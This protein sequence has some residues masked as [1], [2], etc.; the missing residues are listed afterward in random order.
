M[1]LPSSNVVVEPVTTAMTWPLFPRVA[2]HFTR[3]EVTTISLDE[4][5]RSHF[6]LAPML[7]AALRLADAGMDAIAW[8]GTSAAWLGLETDHALCDTITR[9]TG[10]PATT[11]TIAQ[12]EAFRAYGI[13]QYA[14]AVPY[15]E[16]VLQAIIPTFEREGF[17]CVGQAHLGISH[18]RAFADVP[19]DA[20]RALVHAADAPSAEAVA[21]I[22]TNLPAAWLVEELE[23]ELGKPVFDSTILAL[24]H[25]LR[26]AG[27]TE[28]LQGWG[29]LMREAAGGAG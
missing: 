6:D 12:V 3:I 11:S 28:P 18:N 10:V 27:F 21:V 16:S 29:R 13:R 17:R 24:W 26:L 22:C 5:S 4:E 20:I 9:E 2:A 7:R 14:L 19:P 15:L 1:I 8:N 23:A 25:A